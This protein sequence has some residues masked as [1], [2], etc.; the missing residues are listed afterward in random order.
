[1]RWFMKLVMIRAVDRLYSYDV[2][3]FMVVKF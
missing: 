3:S 1:M 2:D